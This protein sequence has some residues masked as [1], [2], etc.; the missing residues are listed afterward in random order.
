VGCVKTK[1]WSLIRPVGSFTA[2][3][4]VGEQDWPRFAGAHTAATT[5]SPECCPARSLALIEPGY[6]EVIGLRVIHTL[7]LQKVAIALGTLVD[8]V[9][10]RQARALA[11]LKDH[12]DERI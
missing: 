2:K 8:G 7:S 3:S 5:H 4:A 12:L 10:R 1:W 6:A 11:R 9:N